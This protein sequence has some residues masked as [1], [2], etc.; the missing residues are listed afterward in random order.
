M[1]AKKELGVKIGVKKV[2]RG[3]DARP[4]QGGKGGGGGELNPPSKHA[5]ES[6]YYRHSRRFDVVN[7][8]PVGGVMGNLFAGLR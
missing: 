8:A 6:M 3:P 4:R 7:Q 1:R 5:S 2:K